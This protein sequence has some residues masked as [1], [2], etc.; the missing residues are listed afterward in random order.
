MTNTRFSLS[1]PM[2][3]RVPFNISPVVLNM[4]GRIMVPPES[5]P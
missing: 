3:D 1:G 5:G 2:D 4:Q